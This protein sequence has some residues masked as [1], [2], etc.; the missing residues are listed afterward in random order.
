MNNV[1]VRS[2]RNGGSTVAHK[3]Q[4]PHWISPVGALR[5]HIVDQVYR[6]PSTPKPL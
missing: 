1:E 3:T 5:L 4:C 6:T 2:F